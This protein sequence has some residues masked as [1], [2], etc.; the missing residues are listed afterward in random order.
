M[1]SARVTI[2]DISR[3][4]EVSIATVSKVLNHDYSRMSDETR[5]RVLRIAGEMNYRPNMLARGLVSHKFKLLGLIIPDIS[6][7]YYGEMARGMT[8]E[9][10]ALDYN[11]MISNTD[12][13]SARG[14]SSIQ[15]MAEYNV[16]GVALTGAIGIAEENL[17]LV[18]HYRIPH[19]IVENHA[20]GLDYCVYVNN[21]SGSYKAAQLLIEYGHREIAY[22]TGHAE[23]HLPGD[24]R[25][26]GFVQAMADAHL[27]VNPALLKCGGFTLDNGYRQTLSLLARGEPF[28]AIACS[29]DL[30][31]LG[32]YKAL[33]ESRLRVPQDISLVGF[34][35]MF[36]TNTM[37]PRLT[38]V[39]QPAYE[40]GEEAIRMLVNRIEENPIAEKVKCFEPLLVS[41]D[42]I[43]PPARRE[44]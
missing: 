12:N 27:P 34:D 37:E 36:M 42:S 35:D 4:A 6:N 43:A 10:Q 1:R 30:I 7:P 2:K 18:R 5:E 26:R 13:Q 20:P 24:E 8:D 29:N 40:I 28:T 21:Y 17:A 9:A 22:I 38:T 33:R 11:A 25:L 31:A 3:R 41:R 44:G 14:I 39:K 32:A 19:V 15:T 23:L 16:S